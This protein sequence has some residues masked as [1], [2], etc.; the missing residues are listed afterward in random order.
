MAF[1]CENYASHHPLLFFPQI[2]IIFCIEQRLALIKILNGNRFQCYSKP[3]YRFL[4]RFYYVV[5]F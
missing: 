1:F 2:P 4:R 5:A 3:C